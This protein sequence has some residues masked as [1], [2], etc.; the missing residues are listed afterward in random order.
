MTRNYYIIGSLIGVLLGGLIIYFLIQSGILGK[1]PVATL[2]PVGEPVS[3]DTVLETVVPGASPVAPNGIVV[4]VFGKVADN[5]A[6]PGTPEAPQQSSSLD[7]EEVPPGAI[8]LVA[9]LDGFTPNSFEVSAGA[10][11]TLSLASGD[12][13]TYVFKFDDSS[14][15]GVAI[16]VAMSDVRAITFNAPTARGEYTFYSDVPGHRDSGLVGKMIVK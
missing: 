4:N 10:A 13:F 15:K 9:K 3:P 5:S 14:L 1:R 2:P 6:N 8:N 16:G 12:G 7:K 11:V